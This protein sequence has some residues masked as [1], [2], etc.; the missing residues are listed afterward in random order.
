MFDVPRV[1]PKQTYTPPG[2]IWLKD[3][4]FI[5]KAEVPNVGYREFIYS[6]NQQHRRR[7]YC[8][9]MLPDTL[10]W[11]NRRLQGVYAAYY[12]LRHPYYQ[13]YPVV[14]ISYYQAL[15]FCK[16]R[17]EQVNYYVA[18]TKKQATWDPATI[19]MGVQYVK[20]RLP[21]DKEWDYAASAGLNHCQYPFGYERIIDKNNIEVSN[22]A[23]YSN[24][25]FQKSKCYSD[26]A[27]A[28][29]S[30]YYDGCVQSV[31]FGE[32]NKY[33]IYNMLGNV[34]EIIADSTIKG[35]SY[36]DFL[37]GP[38]SHEEHFEYDYTID[39]PYKGPRAWLG[40]RCIAE[41]LKQ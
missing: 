22:T 40:F 12:Y 31:F 32:P 21:T 34:S 13:D 24:L 37:N 7:S 38:N 4:L 39:F 41:V 6:I 10:V 20:Y 27:N 18:I 30:I 8:D 1:V 2:T 19:Y 15:E 14:G 36:R 16:W 28:G 11:G 25:F 35:L 3:N 23:E 26:T 9:S 29:D 5:D 33:G 17:T